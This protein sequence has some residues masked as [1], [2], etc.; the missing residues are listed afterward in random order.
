M[1]Q[2][3]ILDTSVIIAALRTSEENHIQCKRLLE[4]VNQAEFVAVEPLIVLVEIASAIKRRTGSQKLS[5]KVVQDIQ[6]M[7]SMFFLDIDVHRA[8]QAIEIAQRYSLRGMDALVVQIAKEFDAHLYSLDLEILDK[9]KDLVVC[10][11]PAS[12]KT[13]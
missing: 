4:L 6:M 3:V 7:S 5:E 10:R 12:Y 2:I 9:V 13:I 11:A 8:Q 1:P